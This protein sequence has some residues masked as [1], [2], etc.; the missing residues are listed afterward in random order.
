MANGFSKLHRKYVQQILIVNRWYGGT[1]LFFCAS[2]AEGF[3]SI[4][5]FT[6]LNIA[7]ARIAPGPV[8]KSSSVAYNADANNVHLIYI[9][10]ALNAILSPPICFLICRRHCAMHACE[11]SQKPFFFFLSAHLIFLRLKS[12]LL[13]MKNLSLSEF[14]DRA[15]DAS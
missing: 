8:V 3:Q 13:E 1:H 11:V 2:E 14:L 7:I 5:P 10:K 15:E 12:N 9:K 4:S 6:M